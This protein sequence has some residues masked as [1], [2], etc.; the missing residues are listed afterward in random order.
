VNGKYQFEIESCRPSGSGVGCRP[1][2]SGV[3]Y[4]GR[5]HFT[6]ITVFKYFA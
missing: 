6:L 5:F 3:C 1:S 4:K 2:G